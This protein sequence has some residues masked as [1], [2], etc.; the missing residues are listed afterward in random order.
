MKID[1]ALLFFGLFGFINCQIDEQL[2]STCMAKC[3]ALRTPAPDDRFIPD[4]EWECYGKCT[5]SHAP[6]CTKENYWKMFSCHEKCPLP[7]KG[8]FKDFR[9]CHLRCSTTCAIPHDFFSNGD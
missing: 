4:F 1:M 2:L 5:N 3:E 9:I 6:R 8:F 7:F